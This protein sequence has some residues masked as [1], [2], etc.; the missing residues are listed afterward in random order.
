MWRERLYRVIVVARTVVKWGWIPLIL[1]LGERLASGPRSEHNAQSFHL[2]FLCM[3][4]V[5]DFSIAWQQCIVYISW[6]K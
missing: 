1:Y 3:R 6:G 2:K 4:H 5:R